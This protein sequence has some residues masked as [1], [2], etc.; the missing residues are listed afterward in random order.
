MDREETKQKLKGFLVQ[1]LTRYR[2]INCNDYFPCLNPNHLNLGKSMH[3]NPKDNTVHCYG[4]GCTYDIF[5]LIG[6]DFNLPHF[7]D[8]LNKACELFLDS[9]RINTPKITR[10][11]ITNMSDGG[12]KIVDYTSFFRVCAKQAKSAEYFR[13]AG[14]TDETA[15]KFNLGYEPEFSLGGNQ[16][17]KA[18][19]IPN[20]P[21]GFWAVNTETDPDDDYVFYYGKENLFCSNVNEGTEDIF[22]TDSVMD[23]LYMAQNGVAS[24]V[25]AN[26]MHLNEF[27][28]FLSQQVKKHNYYITSPSDSRITG[29]VVRELINYEQPNHLVDL[30]YPY[31]RTGDLI[32][33]SPEKFRDR[34]KN[35]RK[36]LGITPK[37]LLARKS[38]EV[39][40]DDAA[41][42]EIY[43]SKG[44]YGIAT[45]VI[46]K[47][48]LLSNWVMD[49]SADSD[50]IYH[51]C[52]SEWNILSV[53]LDARATDISKSYYS[54]LPKIGLS[55]NT[56][57]PER[58]AGNLLTV[59][60]SKKIRRQEGSVL[61]I[62]LQ[63][64]GPEYVRTFVN[65]LMGELR[66]YIHSIIF[67]CLEDGRNLIDEFCWQ[68]F[69][70]QPDVTPDEA[71]DDGFDGRDYRVT[72]CGAVSGRVRFYTTL[73]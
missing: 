14:I 16:Q 32:L 37:K 46:T 33:A 12:T 43:Y 8:Q 11:E 56:G 17:I 55:E 54:L 22:I 23:S 45:D 63:N 21:Y 70:V 66:N 4:C 13:E 9:D 40:S 52:I 59:F 53:E 7:Q 20:G 65:R 60:A 35:I 3:F 68:T 2:K 26:E 42:S 39:I 50:F 18:M 73:E 41:F 51:T 1:Y 58:D 6:S 10:N 31:Q 57:D 49:S 15:A 71:G 44:V 72:A 69:T 48:K 47:R 67:F 19:I 27:V 30:A 61:V 38:Y 62:N 25:I 34:V 5:S 24:L 28:Y 64:T 29:L 36:L